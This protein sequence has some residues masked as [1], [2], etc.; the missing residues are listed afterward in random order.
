[1]KEGRKQ[2]ME[3]QEDRKMGQGHGHESRT[4]ER[5]RKLKQPSKNK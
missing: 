1:M 4:K 2:G 3:G 5:K